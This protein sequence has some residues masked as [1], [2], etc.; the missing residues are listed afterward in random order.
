MNGYIQFF[1][2]YGTYISW[3]SIRFLFGWMSLFGGIEYSYKVFSG[4]WA[5]GPA[6]EL[7]FLSFILNI[8]YVVMAASKMRGISY[9]FILSL[10]ILISILSIHTSILCLSNV[11]RVNPQKSQRYYNKYL[12]KNR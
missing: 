8:T 11:F 3:D 6:F 9:R 5:P 7:F 10:C 2:N 12:G 1:V 4:V